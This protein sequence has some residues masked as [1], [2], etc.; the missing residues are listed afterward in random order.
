MTRR[1][2]PRNAPPPE[3]ATQ[4]APAP[5]VDDDDDEEEPDESDPDYSFWNAS[6][7]PDCPICGEPWDGPPCEHQ[8]ADLD[9]A[10]HTLEGG[11]LYDE[12]IHTL[13]AALLAILPD[14]PRL[15]VRLIPDGEYEEL[16][17]RY[18][19]GV[20]QGEHP[21][22]ALHDAGSVPFLL[23]LLGYF[24]VRLEEY[25]VDE[26]TG[27][28]AYHSWWAEDP[29]GIYEEL[30]DLLEHA[31]EPA[32][33]NVNFASW[34]AVDEALGA[35]TTLPG[36]L[37]HSMLHLLPVTGSPVERAAILARLRV[38]DIPIVLACAEALIGND[39]AD[40]AAAIR[41]DGRYD[42]PSVVAVAESLVRELQRHVVGHVGCIGA[43]DHRVVARIERVKT[44]IK[45][46]AEP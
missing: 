15:V 40:V 32:R 22:D 39:P 38:P 2:T 30:L 42:R 10:Y 25:D 16:R 26:A 19:E 4:P 46:V 45:A 24:D 28:W 41:A 14:C 29:A 18:L 36:R 44:F 35:G 20:R 11:F 9:V 5:V 13:E 21:E 3:P 6:G 27:R 43:R 37:W 8:V 34:A 33:G 7:Y 31:R 12:P 17:E 1:K 23:H